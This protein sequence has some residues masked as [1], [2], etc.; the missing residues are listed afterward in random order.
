MCAL[1][2]VLLIWVRARGAVN[3]KQTEPVTVHARQYLVQAACRSQ[4][5]LTGLT[6]VRVSV[7]N[8]YVVVYIFPSALLLQ[9][10]RAM[11]CVKQIPS[12]QKIIIARARAELSTR[13]WKHTS[14]HT[15]I[16]THTHT[17]THAAI[18][19]ATA[20]FILIGNMLSCRRIHS[21]IL[22][23]YPRM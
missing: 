5:R 13:F 3:P 16:N 7:T 12:M 22:V 11:A 20:L 10:S 6:T 18:Y 1:N 19:E 17:H 21:A 2:V 14:I 23:L 9:H 4:N 15:N 8:V